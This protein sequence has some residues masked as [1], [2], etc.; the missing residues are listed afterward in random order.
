M[1]SYL[2]FM[3][4]S[5]LMALWTALGL[6]P[7]AKPQYWSR[8]STGRNNVRMS[9]GSLWCFALLSAGLCIG[10]AGIA[11]EV[12]VVAI[13]GWCMFF[14]AGFAGVFFMR[15]DVRRSECGS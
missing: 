11:F 8:R 1:I 15:G 7:G 3:L 12:R 6:R 13:G 10:V 5:G 9:R 4:L 14:V 2:V